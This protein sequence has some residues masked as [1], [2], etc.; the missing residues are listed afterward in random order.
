MRKRDEIITCLSV[1]FFL[2]GSV[3]FAR[4]VCEAASRFVAMASTMPP[5]S[6]TDSVS[7]DIPLALDIVAQVTFYN[8]KSRGSAK[9]KKAKTTT[10][11]DTRAKEFTFTFAPSKDN[12]LA[13]LQEIL[14][15][16]H[17]S[18]YKVS[19]QLVFPCKVQVPP[20]R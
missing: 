8:S 5:D 7:S 2:C 20:A 3:G 10:V 16:H 11:K 17:I 4:S 6:P 9:G 14:D 15:K 1:F 13:F 18:K 19:D 12:Y